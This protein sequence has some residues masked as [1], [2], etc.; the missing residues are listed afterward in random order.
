MNGER[1]GGFRSR[2][3]FVRLALSIS[4]GGVPG[5]FGDSD[6]Q[7]KGGLRNL[8]EAEAN[9]GKE[10]TWELCMGAVESV[11]SWWHNW[12]TDRIRDGAIETYCTAA[13]TPSMTTLGLPIGFAMA[14]LK[15]F[16]R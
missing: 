12:L 10:G 8:A 4:C 2:E 14:R 5:P 11:S 3:F 9:A 6:A 13:V 1:A 15:H 7:K 16:R